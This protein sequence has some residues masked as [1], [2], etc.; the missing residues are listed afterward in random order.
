MTALPATHG[1]GPPQAV[2]DGRPGRKLTFDK[3]SF[4]L[5]FLVLP[6]A[7][8]IGFVVSPFVQAAYF[9]LTDW[10]G[11]TPAMNFIGLSNF[12]EAVHRRHLPASHGQ[13]HSAWRSWSRS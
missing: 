4:F 6:V 11:F 3:I 10:T 1:P 8:Y 2:R 13:Q 5:V 7:F 12:R 9:S